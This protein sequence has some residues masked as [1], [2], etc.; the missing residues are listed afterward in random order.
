MKSDV[1]IHRSWGYSKS[2]VKLE[3]DWRN[4]PG[5]DPRKRKGHSVLS[6]LVQVHVLNEE[7]Q[8]RLLKLEFRILRFLIKT[9]N[10]KECIESYASNAI[11][12]IKR[13]DTT[14]F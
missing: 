5:L 2:K 12:M 10:I 14:L 13:K 8:M 7:C 6:N 11:L 9:A 1:R 4:C 3:K